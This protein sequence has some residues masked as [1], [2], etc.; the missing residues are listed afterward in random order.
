MKFGALLAVAL[1]VVGAVSAEAANAAL[2]K[3]LAETFRNVLPMT[4]HALPAKPEQKV[5]C[6]LRGRD[7]LSYQKAFSVNAFA[8][9]LALIGISGD[10]R[11]VKVAFPNAA[12][13]N[14]FTNGWFKA[15]DVFGLR[16]PIVWRDSPREWAASN[17]VQ[18][19][20]YR[21]N[22]RN[23]P[24]LSGCL[25]RG[26]EG[27][28]IG[29]Q[30]FKDEVFHLV[31]CVDCNHT[32]FGRP[33]RG[34][35]VLLKEHGPF[36]N[37]QYFTRM[38]ELLGEA[39][40]QEGLRWTNATHP[41]LVPGNGNGGCAAAVT[42]F[43]GYMYG[44]RN[45]NAGQ[46]FDDPKEIRSGDVIALKGHF[47]A[48]LWREGDIL[49]TFEGN[50]NSSIHRSSRFYSMKDGRLH[51]GKPFSHGWHYVD[52]E[53]YT[54]GDPRKQKNAKSERSR[55]ALNFSSPKLHTLL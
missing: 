29:E 44:V 2:S 32:V 3:P 20:V 49:H 13:P 9:E 12:S 14:G 19:L 35:L 50:F 27:W 15:D 6:P 18:Y 10:G 38:N 1:I 30:R 52:R 33:M 17:G 5:V 48:V 36:T 45:F 26:L 41:L 42:D 47:M 21:P 55:N 54:G 28:L 25:R 8:D 4:F 16:A 24:V 43:A 53:L 40:Y 31:C 39:P 23:R 7:K 37:D 34:R 11:R 51:G 22:G 46:R